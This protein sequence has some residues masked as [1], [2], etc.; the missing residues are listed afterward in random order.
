LAKA[1]ARYDNALD[2]DEITGYDRTDYYYNPAWQVL[3]QHVVANAAN[4]DTVATS[5]ERQYVWCERYIDSPVVRF[6]NADAQPDL[7]EALYYA[8]DANMNVTALVD[9]AGNV[10]ERYNYE[11]YGQFRVYDAAWTADADNATD[12]ANE[13]L[14]AGYRFDSETHSID[15]AANDAMLTGLYHVRHRQYNSTLGHWLQRDPLGYVDGMNAYG[16][17]GQSPGFGM[18]PSGCVVTVSV[19]ASRLTF[20]RRDIT[21]PQRPRM[22]GGLEHGS[23][24]YDTYM[25]EVQEYNKKLREPFLDA[26]VRY[27]AL[28][29]PCVDIKTKDGGKQVYE[30]R[31]KRPVTR[32]YAVAK[33]GDKPEEFCKCAKQNP[34]GTFL[35]YHLMAAD[36]VI[37]IYAG[38]VA[39]SGP[40]TKTGEKLRFRGKE[41]RFVGWY[42]NRTPTAGYDDHSRVS[43]QAAKDKRYRIRDG[44]YRVDANVADLTAELAHEMQHSYDWLSGAGKGKDRDWKEARAIQTGNRVYGAVMTKLGHP[45]VMGNRTVYD[46]KPVLRTQGEVDSGHFHGTQLPLEDVS[47]VDLFKELKDGG[48]GA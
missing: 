27:L 5:L 16:Y 37:E 3:E 1:V 23:A 42:L 19:K 40:E 29:S 25:G 8:N 48:W 20:E 14:Y 24:E 17:A 12:V 45:D 35:L 13:I 7:E 10:V 33:D 6:R 34:D 36:E 46:V 2:P 4:P 41:G 15:P 22:P 31:K 30:D 26:V 43:G 47:W 44:Q 11:P 39:H 28:L 9:A 18:D 21:P 32:I 38:T